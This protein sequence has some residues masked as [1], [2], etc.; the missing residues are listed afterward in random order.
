MIGLGAANRR[1]HETR[2]IKV[3]AEMYRITIDHAGSAELFLNVGVVGCYFS[4]SLHDG[5]CLIEGRR[6][7]SASGRVLRKVIEEM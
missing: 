4:R 6:A 3:A 1:Q 2:P 7:T 5:S